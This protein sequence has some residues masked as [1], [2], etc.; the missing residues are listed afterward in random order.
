[1]TEIGEFFQ[2]IPDPR[3]ERTRKHDLVEIIVMSVL[4]TIC[5]ADTWRDVADFAREREDLLRGTLSLPNGIPSP[6]TFR[7]VFTALDPVAFNAAFTEWTKTLCQTT[8]GKL[9][10]LDGKTL[11]GSFTT[12]GKQDARH[13][14]SAWVGENRVVLGQVST[15]AKSNEI[16]A[17]PK[18]LDMLD[19]KGATITIDAM[20]CQKKIVRKIVDRGGDYVV[21]VKD[22]QPTLSSAVEA[23]FAT[24]DIADGDLPTH[25]VHDSTNRGHGRTERRRV[26]AIDASGWLSEDLAANW[27]GLHTL[28][29]VESQRTLNGH[30]AEESRLYISS[31]KADA[32]TLGTAIREHWGIENSQ[33]WTLDMAF[34]EDRSRTRKKNAPDNQA[35]LRRIALNILKQASN[36]SR[37]KHLSVKGKRLKAAWSDR[38]LGELLQMVGGYRDGDNVG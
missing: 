4:A 1:M 34:D 32:A 23:A 22:N 17:I 9:I 38:Y 26:T 19:I 36:K 20:G 8:D 28:V 2:G 6:D 24:L 11:R 31:A 16:T 3:V 30:T 29:R 25:G 15:D 7:R 18:L 14:V 35:L 27:A 37:G 10:A 5:A 33:H 13:I 12:P 21:A